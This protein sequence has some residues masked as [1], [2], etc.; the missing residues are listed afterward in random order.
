MRTGRPKGALILTEDERQRLEPQGPPR[1]RP[2]RAPVFKR[3]SR[4]HALNSFAKD[5]EVT[6]GCMTSYAPPSAL[7]KSVPN[8]I[9]SRSAHGPVRRSYRVGEKTPTKSLDFAPGSPLWSGPPRSWIASITRS[10]LSL[11]PA[12]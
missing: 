2:W 3:L 4:R 11:E 1:H 8:S 5:K 12:E 9:A 10:Q 7:Q 6:G